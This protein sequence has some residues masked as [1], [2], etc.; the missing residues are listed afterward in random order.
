MQIDLRSDTLTQPTPPMKK[1]MFEAVVGDDVFGED[2]TLKQL[3]KTMANLFGHEAAL[4]CPSGTMTNQ[5]AIKVHTQPGT[6]VIC[7]RLSHIYLYEGGGVAS[8]SYA[9][10]RLLEG[11]FGRI[12]AEQIAQ[13]INNPLD[14]HQPITS[15]VV[16]ENTVNKGG[17]VYYSLESIQAIRQ[18]CQKNNLPLHLDGAR[19][20]NALVETGMSPSLLGPQFDSISVCLSKGLGCPVGSVLIGSESFIQ[21]A[22]RVRKALGGGIRQGG[23]LAAAGLYAIEHHIDRLKEDH[24]RARQLGKWVSELPQVEYVYDIPTNIVLF[25]L[26]PEVNPQDFLTE[27]KKKG[28]LAISFGGQLIRLVTHLDVQ[29]PHLDHFYQSMH[30]D[31]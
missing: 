18:V 16:L 13:N 2:P 22:K 28:I 31:L 21:K 11:D 14:I 25:A 3:E 27:W 7:D 19:I 9:S 4:F 20:F 6:E 1:A 17:G 10:M 29:D 15:L 26:K 23:F 12:S 8:N 30:L 24:S 5:I